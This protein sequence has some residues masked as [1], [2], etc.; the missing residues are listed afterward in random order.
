MY[1]VYKH[2]SPSGKVYIGITR[3]DPRKR[4]ANGEGYRTQTK[5]Y[6]AIS[7]YGW[8]SFSH[9]ILY[10]NLSPSEAEEKERELIMEYRSFDKR[11]G[12]NCELGG[13]FSKEISDETRERMRE[14]HR[15][16][17]YREL[18][19]RVNE[20]RWS[21]PAARE[22]MSQ[23][24]KGENNPMYGKTI[25]E[26]HRAKLR[27]NAVPPPPPGFG[28]ENHFYGK[29]HSEE[30]KKLI[31]TANRGENNGRAKRVC[32]LETGVVYG[33]VRDA[34]R[35]TGVHFSS[36]AKTCNGVLSS[37]GGYH[38]QFVDEKGGEQ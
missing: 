20:K 23:R 10:S 29:H 16:P 22:K 5:F 21:D 37:A 17:E 13:N 9:E 33:S 14:A 11:F 1:S 26:E 18:A 2:T 27:E 7:K 6:R 31:S 38:W 36:I 8:E 19:R 32:C 12:Y 28:A 15:T 30:T 3:Q 4:W 35:A 25:S 24:F 34:F